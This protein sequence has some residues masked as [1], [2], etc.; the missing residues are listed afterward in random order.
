MSSSSFFAA[1]FALASAPAQAAGGTVKVTPLGS[2]AGE[3]C[4][5]DRALLFEDPNGTTIL[6]DAGLT[7]NGSADTRVPADLDL[8]LLTHTHGDHLGAA[9]LSGGDCG[10]PAFAAPAP[11]TTTADVVA[12]TVAKLF[13]GLGMQG[14]LQKKVVAAGGTASQV[15]VLLYGGSR[16]IGGVK[17]AVVGTVHNNNLGAN[18]LSDATHAAALAA[19]GLSAYVGPT[20]GYILQFTNGLKVYLSGDTG[21][22][23]DMKLIVRDFY[24]ANLAVLN[25]GNIFTMGPE[26]AAFAANK[27]IKPKSV[28]ASHAN[29]E[30]TSGGVVIAGTKTDQFSKLVKVPVHVPTSGDVMEFNGNGKCVAG[31]C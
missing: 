4:A 6:F 13:V 23:S 28:I 22:T 7:V 11:N 27:L 2:E 16:T 15:D 8:V 29:E 21:H 5:R 9:F 25:I 17:V 30:A 1:L 31:A 24:K 26:E 20:H 12:G 10:N 3:F 14:F 18:F 19:D